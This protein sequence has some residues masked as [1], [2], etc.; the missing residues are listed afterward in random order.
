MDNP[1]H[2]ARE[3]LRHTVATVAYR[4]AKA[5]RGVTPEFPEFRS[6]ESTRTP[7]R[8]LAHVNDLFD[9][10]LWL[11]RGEHRWQDSTPQP[12][13]SEVRRFFDTLAHFDE[14]LAS[15]RPLGN[16]PERLFQGPVA[17]ALTHIGQIAMLRRLAGCPVR[18]ENYFKADIVPG[19]VGPDQTAPRREFD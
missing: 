12:W 4:G 9:W 11:A 7:L 16:P 13:E 5:L 18:G 8:I 17:D 19:R 1:G 10:A 2:V 6:G 15:D 3:L 14:Y